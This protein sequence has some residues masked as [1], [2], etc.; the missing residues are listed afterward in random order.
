MHPTVCICNDPYGSIYLYE[1]RGVVVA[2][3][4][5]MAANVKIVV[6]PIVTLPG[7]WSTGMYKES[8]P[9]ITKSP[10]GK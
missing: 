6:I 3:A 5:N 9:I 8:H 2:M 4:E 7:T 10:E 1:T